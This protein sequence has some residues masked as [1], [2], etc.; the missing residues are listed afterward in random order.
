MV[1][2]WADG[3][4]FQ[5]LA[6]WVPVSMGYDGLDYLSIDLVVVGSQHHFTLTSRDWEHMIALGSGQKCFR[7]GQFI[8]R[9]GLGWILEDAEWGGAG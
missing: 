6:G 8:L 4:G 5:K 9:G 3:N 2:V 7:W 1:F